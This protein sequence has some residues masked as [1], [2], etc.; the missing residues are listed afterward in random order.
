MGDSAGGTLP[1]VL[2]SKPSEACARW[3]QDNVADF[4]IAVEEYLVRVVAM[5]DCVLVGKA[6]ISNELAY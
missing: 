6:G 3:A 4:D 2:G 1:G 5:I